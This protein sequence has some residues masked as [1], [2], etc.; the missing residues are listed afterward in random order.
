MSKPEPEPKPENIETII[1]MCYVS[2]LFLLFFNH[3][4][5]TFEP[6]VFMVKAILLALVRMEDY[7]LFVDVCIVNNRTKEKRVK[8]K[9]KIG[10]GNKKGEKKTNSIW[11]PHNQYDF[12]FVKCSPICG[13]FCEN[14]SYVIVS[15]SITVLFI[16]YI[17]YEQLEYENIDKPK[18]DS[19]KKIWQRRRRRR[20]RKKFD[21]FLPGAPN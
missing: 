10:I 5:M 20:S 6:Y 21:L 11:M 16:Q 19:E 4:L 2:F 18:N 1:F 3:P 14:I 13:T 12:A 9:Q 7:Y 15:Q 17:A 8:L